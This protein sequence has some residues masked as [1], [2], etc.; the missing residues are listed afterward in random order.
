MYIP[1]LFRQDSTELLHEVI[2]Q[3]SFAT[4]VTIRQGAPFASHLP[5]L[6]DSARGEQGALLGHM[7]RAN[8]QWK[9]FDS[10]QE[11][12]VVFQGPHA[13]VSPSW[14]EGSLHVPTWNYVAV[15]AYAVP[16]V[17]DDDAEFY[18]LLQTMVDKFEGAFE[19]P[20]KFDL[21]SDYVQ[22]MMKAIV[23]FELRITRLEGK[24]KLSQN[25][26]EADQ[27]RVTDILASSSDPNAR[28]V[29]EWMAKIYK[30]DSR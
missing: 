14:Y 17:I 18:R 7:A 24:E 16:R 23:G 25:R 10:S 27:R 12:L 9:D 20:W 5:F 6:L 21:P 19:K 28:G 8:P 2:Q 15:H 11:V 26:D 3:F 1:R 29:A 13:Y 4:L 22:E 30:Y